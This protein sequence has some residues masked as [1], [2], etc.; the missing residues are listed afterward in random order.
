ML[1]PEVCY[2]SVHSGVH[3]T[4]PKKSLGSW[5]DVRFWTEKVVGGLGF[6]RGNRPFTGS[7]RQIP[8]RQPI[9]NGQKGEASSFLR[10]LR[11]ILPVYHTL[12]KWGEGENCGV[13]CRFFLSLFRQE[14]RGSQCWVLFLNNQI[15]ILSWRAH[16]GVARL[17]PLQFCLIYLFSAYYL[18]GWG[19][20]A[21][22]MKNIIFVPKECSLV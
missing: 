16:L 18:A 19:R 11:W 15:K 12:F 7:L 3:R 22:P 10:F 21:H 13:I 14:R 17:G 9:N 6:R 4:W 20:R 1:M 2:L 8:A 5:G